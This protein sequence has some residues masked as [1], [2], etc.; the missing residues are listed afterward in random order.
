MAA[1]VYKMKF[2]VGN[3]L[4]KFFPD[5]RWCYRIIFAPDKTGGLLNI[6]KLFAHIISDSA[7]GKGNDLDYF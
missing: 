4:M 5:K 2:A 7:F 3:E 1:F 6:F